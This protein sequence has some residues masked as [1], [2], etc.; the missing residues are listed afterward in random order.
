[1]DDHNN[2]LGVLQGYRTPLTMCKTRT[3]WLQ[4]IVHLT[5]RRVTSVWT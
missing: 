4:T 5:A 3:F 2:F 1:M